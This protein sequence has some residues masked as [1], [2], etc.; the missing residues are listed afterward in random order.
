MITF[1]S[2]WSKKNQRQALEKIEDKRGGDKTDSNSADEFRQF[3]ET[4]SDRIREEIVSMTYQPDLVVEYEIINGK[5]KKRMV[6]TYTSTDRF[7]TRL[8]TQKLMLFYNPL[9]LNSSHAFQ[10]NKGINTAVEEARDYIE[11]GCTHVVE[12]DLKNFFDEIS[13]ERMMD[14][15]KKDINDK[16]VLYLLE[17]Y[18]YCSISND[19]KI[20]TK[21]KGLVQGSSMSPVLSN[22][23]L[24]EFDRFLEENGCKWVRFA[25]D[26]R[27]YV[28]TEQ[29]GEAIFP[30][31]CCKL[32]D[33]LLLKINEQKSGI[34]DSTARRFLGYD[35]QM[36]G[37][38]VILRKHM[39]QRKNH[40]RDW[41]PCA[42]EKVNKE[43]HLIRNGV[44]NKKDF[45]LLFENEEEKHHI[46]VEAT[47][48][49]NIYNEIVITS[50][51]I[52]TITNENIRIGFF[53]R[54]GEL[55]GYYVPHGYTQD[56]KATLAQCAEYSD[57][58]KRLL[59]A[60][61]MEIAAIHNIRANL[62]YYHKHG[63]NV[64]GVIDFLN[65][66]IDEF[67]KCKTIE[68]LL[69]IEA[70]CRQEYYRTFNEILNNRDFRFEK[71]SKRP[72]LDAI[73]AL[74][75]FGNTVL[76]NK[77]QHMIWKTS[78]DP[79]IGI[80]HAAN[81]RYCSLNLDFADL[82]KAITVDRVIFTIIN[83]GIIRK[84]NFVMHGEGAVY[85]DDNGKRLFIQEFEDKMSSKITINN[86]NITYSQLIE[87][88][89]HA[90][91]KHILTESKYKPYKYY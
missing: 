56:S 32:K 21:E 79:R 24:L 44:L 4:N 66:Q 77:I 82:F 43:Y 50:S 30:L 15:L 57:L 37:K 16:V 20:R 38:K 54:V 90:Y 9:F 33:E 18:L 3:W 73:N 10:N 46:P 76:Y 22:L 45:A 86:K 28:E 19:G 85:L 13:L 84:D 69:L 80:F 51:V 89:I 42:V 52:N 63:K 23:Y 5:G 47:E 72:P 49:I 71:R 59:M 8:L 31:I 12:I 64:D 87:N 17:K 78:L 60:K 81:R 25:D 6:S 11:F 14:I 7:I 36:R 75:S 48:Q 65:E 35:F 1:E 26:I 41:H 70:R 58:A 67:N 2:V 53:N 27:V 68:E 29:Q 88:E 83:K 39:Y 40:F 62:R 74:I 61:R 34:Y 55:L 91:Q